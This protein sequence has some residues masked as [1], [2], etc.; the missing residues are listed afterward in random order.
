MLFR[1]TVV[2]QDNEIIH[3]VLPKF[4]RVFMFDSNMLHAARPVSRVC[5]DLRA[6]L[7]FKTFDTS[8]IPPHINFINEH[9]LNV[10]HS[11]RT[12]FEHLF[13]TMSILERRK[14]SDDVLLAGLYHSIYGT[15]SF[16]Y[17][18]PNIN[19]DL[20]KSLIGEYSES[21]VYEFCT[22]KNRYETIK[23][24][25]NNYNEKMHID[26]L[27][28]EIANLTDQNSKGNITDRINALEEVRKKLNKE[29]KKEEILEDYSI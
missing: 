16:K 7:V 1:S 14:N 15:E 11:G 3:S 12:F 24:N 18:N 4:G 29:K 10:K 8:A 5:S 23:Q 17:E 22:L 27:E 28:M 2:F 13:G 6:V 21:L 20:I 25:S 9:T 26:L 19:R